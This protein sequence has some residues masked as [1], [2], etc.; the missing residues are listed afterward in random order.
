M[1]NM[2]LFVNFFVNLV[3]LINPFIVTSSFIALAGHATQGQQRELALRSCGIALVMGCAFA[4]FGLSLL[5]GAGISTAALRIAGGFL[6]FRTAIDLVSSFSNEGDS[7]RSTENVMQFSVFPIGFPTI[8][9]P[10]ALCIIADTSSKIAAPSM[11]DYLGFMVAITAVIGLNFAFM[12]VAPQ[13]LNVMG[14]A[15]VDLVKRLV[16]LFLSML[17]AQ[18]MITGCSEAYHT[19][20]HPAPHQNISKLEVGSSV[21]CA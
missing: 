3:I 6:L 20:F 1:E 8:V 14:T 4:L 16:G 7:N 9:G 21:R 18:I 10:G 12:W 2:Q 19:Y 15:M 13:I 5:Q 17:S 11:V